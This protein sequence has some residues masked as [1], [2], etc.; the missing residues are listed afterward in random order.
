MSDLEFEKLTVDH[1]E[2]EPDETSVS[3]VKMLESPIVAVP[4][5]DDKLDITEITGTLIEE[6]PSA[7]LFSD[8]AEA[9][10]ED[11]SVE[12][13]WVDEPIELSKGIEV[14]PDNELDSK[15]I[16]ESSVI[17]VQV[18]ASATVLVYVVPFITVVETCKVEWEE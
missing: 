3:F 4:L 13:T 5:A 9:T 2:L 15:L 14:E 10:I 11:F 16:V 12:E 6:G 1:N 8:G 7:K 18:L 17:V